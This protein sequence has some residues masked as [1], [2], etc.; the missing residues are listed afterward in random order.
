M[1]L[2]SGNGQNTKDKSQSVVLASDHGPLVV[3]ITGADVNVDIDESNL[4]TH[5]DLVA[6]NASLTSVDTKLTSQASAA[7]QTTAH[8]KLDTIATDV[9]RLSPIGPGPGS[10]TPAQSKIFGFAFAANTAAQFDLAGA[11]YAGLKTAIDAGKGLTLK[12]TTGCL[13]NWGTGSITIAAAST[14]AVN[15]ATQGVPMF[16]GE[17]SDER[18]P[19]GTTYMNILG[20]AVAG[21]L[22][23]VI[24][25]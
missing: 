18:A 23:A 3:T 16:D 12:A 17:R 6:A 15:P 13:Y 22:Y 1:N 19:S 14:A 7:N 25:E 21:T 2:P 11:A 9:K 20:G 10:A 5:A 8:T 24:A 4:A